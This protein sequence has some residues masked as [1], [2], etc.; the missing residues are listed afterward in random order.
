MWDGYIFT[1]EWT[2]SVFHSSYN[3]SKCWEFIESEKLSN[4][5]LLLMSVTSIY[6]CFTQ[7]RD[8]YFFSLKE[9]KYSVFHSKL[10]TN[11]WQQFI[12]VTF[13]WRW[14]LCLANLKLSTKILKMFEIFIW[15]WNKFHI[16]L[17]NKWGNL[18]VPVLQEGQVFY[19]Y[20]L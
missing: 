10:W 3:H 19:L 4:F 14:N 20:Y 9:W 17:R 1:V 8:D 7:T 12:Y 11:L 5:H 2:I 15:E 16:S 6:L 18:W 13:T